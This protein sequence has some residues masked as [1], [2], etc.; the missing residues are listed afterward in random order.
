MDRDRFTFVWRQAIT[1]SRYRRRDDGT[2]TGT[3]EEF[4]YFER[5]DLPLPSCFMR[6]T[7]TERLADLSLTESFAKV[8]R[9]DATQPVCTVVG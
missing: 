6:I 9:N 4:A 2:P 1:L 8:K 3:L 7:S 5:L